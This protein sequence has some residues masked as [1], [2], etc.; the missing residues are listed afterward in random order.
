MMS[1]NLFYLAKPLYGGWVSFT[2]HLSLKYDLP[3]YKITKR[4][5]KKKRPYGYGVEYQNVSEDVAKGLPNCIITAIDKTYYDTLS[6]F[7]DGTHIV[8]HDPTEVKKTSDIALLTALKRFNVITIRKSVQDYL[9]SELNILSK[10][11]IHP[12]YAYPYTKCPTPHTAVSTSRID[13]DKHTDIILDANKTLAEPISLY[14]AVNGRYVCF[15]L[16]DAEF[17]KY[18]KGTFNKTFEAL[19]NILTDAKFVVDMSIIKKDGGGSQYTFLEALYQECALVINKKWTD[20]MET[21]Y[22]YGENCFIVETPQELINVI[23]TED[24]SKVLAGAKL[25]LQPHIDVNW[26]EELVKA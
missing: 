9:Q 5:E 1:H 4:T 24:Y 13:Y 25:I 8:I 12:F 7:P 6:S 3:L 21:P 16:D 23:T 14:G 22:K 11:I 17:H 15:K 26:I 2:A 20:N 19:N 18:H 10:H